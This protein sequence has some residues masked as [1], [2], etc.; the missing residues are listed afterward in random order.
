M[1]AMFVSVMSICIAGPT[2]ESGTG[3]CICF[4]AFL[5]LHCHMPGKGILLR[6]LQV[7][8]FIRALDC[9]R[10]QIEVQMLDISGA[11]AP[12]GVPTGIRSTAGPQGAEMLT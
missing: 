10:E 7:V 5:S 6:V 4:H 3:A 1:F 9:R 2:T 8:R 11:V 12:K